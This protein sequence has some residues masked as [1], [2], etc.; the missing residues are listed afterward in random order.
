MIE[1]DVS[2]RKEEGKAL[3][4]KCP[5]VRDSLSERLQELEQIWSSLLEKA[6]QRKQRLQQAEAV[7]RYLTEWRELM[8]AVFFFLSHCFS[9]AAP[10]FYTNVVDCVLGAGLRR[11]CL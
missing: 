3:V 7:Q 1:E 6:N 11:H 2:R 10:Q 9:C 5:Q 4:R 8:Y